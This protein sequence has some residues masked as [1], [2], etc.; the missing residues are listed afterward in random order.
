MAKTD[1]PFLLLATRPGATLWILMTPPYPPWREISDEFHFTGL[2]V[3]WANLL[4]TT[5]TD[6]TTSFVSSGRI[7][8][9]YFDNLDP[10]SWVMTD[11]RRTLPVTA[12]CATLTASS[13]VL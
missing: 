13:S 1:S 7:D 5:R 4:A 2:S 9:N 11:R 12:Y 6:A 3:C 10:G 8:P